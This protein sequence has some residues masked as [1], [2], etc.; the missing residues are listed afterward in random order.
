MEVLHKVC[1]ECDEE[2]SEAA[3][4]TAVVMMRAMLAVEEPLRFAA[5]RPFLFCVRHAARGLDLFAGRVAVPRSWRGGGGEGGGE[6]DGE[7]GCRPGGDP[8]CSA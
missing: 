7:P 5:D 4:A 2:G 3:A 1:V 6:G 8:V